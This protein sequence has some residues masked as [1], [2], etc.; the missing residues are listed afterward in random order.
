MFVDRSLKI[1]VIASLVATV[2]YI[3][4]LDPLLRLITFVLFNV[5]G[6]IFQ[7]YKDRLFAHAALLV[8]PDSGLALYS[9]ATGLISGM[10]SGALFGAF[11]GPRSLTKEPKSA[12]GFVSVKLWRIVLVLFSLFFIPLNL[13]SIHS[14]FFQHRVTSSFSQ[15]L[16]AID[17]YITDQETK[18]FRSRWTQMQSEADYK[19]I[20]RDIAGIAAAHGVR[21]PENEVFSMSNILP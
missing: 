4:L 9:L 6:F 3:Y 20:Y 21:L 19:A 10:L 2:S 1:G 15:H 13:L 11:V 7:T 18:V 17:P 5:S 16:A 8:G 12:P 14:A